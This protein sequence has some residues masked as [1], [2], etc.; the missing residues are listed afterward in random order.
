MN[1]SNRLTFSLV[2]SVLLVA[3]FALV[4]TVMAA[5]GGP[6]ATITIDDSPIIQ[7]GPD[8]DLEMTDDNV[9]VETVDGANVL[10]TDE[11]R[12]NLVTSGTGYFRVKVVF[13]EA[14]FNDD[15]ETD[16]D[17]TVAVNDLV[18]TDAAWTI[19]AGA[20]VGGAQLTGID[21]T[22]VERV[23]TN[24]DPDVTELSKTD[25][26]VTL[27][28]S[29]SDVPLVL[30]LTLNA[31]QVYGVGTA[32]QIVNGVP[33]Q[34]VSGTGNQ[35]AS[36]TFTVIS[37][38]L[39]KPTVAV[40]E[41]KIGLDESLTVT[42]TFD[43]A[44]MGDD[45]PSRTNIKVT[46]GSI[47]P[48]NP[49]TDGDDGLYSNAD[50]A[51]DPNT[52]WTIV[53][54]PQG[55]IGTFYKMKVE[56]IAGAP[57]V[58]SEEITVDSTPLEQRIDI[59]TTSTSDSRKGG[60]EFTVAIR[61]NVAPSS[62]LTADGVT[63]TGGAKGTFN[64]SG[65]D[66]TLVV[67][68]TD[69]AAGATGT[70]TVSVG[71]YSQSFDIPGVDV[72]TDDDDDDPTD[73]R[74]TSDAIAIPKNSFVVVVRDAAAT[75][76]P[77]GQVFRAGVTKVEWA[78][79]PN[80]QELFDRSAPGGGG[81]IVVEDASTPANIAVGRVGI[82][83][84]MWGIDEG[85]LGLAS[86]T[87]SQWIELHN[88]SDKNVM[89]KL[90]SL[91]GRDITDDSKITG[92][93]TAP[94]VDVVTNFFNN[95]IGNPAW[96][97]LGSNGNT[98]S[99]ASFVSM[100]R[101]LPHRKAAYADADGA[102]FSNRDGRA[103]GHWTSSSSV[104]VR[105][106]VAVGDVQVVY[107]YKGTP[108]QVNSFKPQTQPNLKDARTNVPSNG[109]VINE[110]ANRSD[111]D[112]AYEWI[113][114]YNA[115][116]GEIN[117]RNYRISK[118]ITNIND[119][120]LLDF[121]T[122]DN[123]KIGAG[124]VLLIVASD[125]AQDQEH[126][127]AVGYNVD[128]KAEEQAPGLADNPVRYKVLEFKN[129]GLP[130]NGKFVLIVRRPDNHENKN[131]AGKGPA[132]LGTADLDKIVD[133]AGWHD[134]LG[135]SNYSNPVSSTGL[136][137]LR[138]FAG[139]FTNRNQFGENSVHY[140]QYRTTNDGRSGVGAHENKNQDDRAAF[141]NAGFTG[142]GYKRRITSGNAYAG[143][144][145]YEN[146]VLKS[147]GGA[148]TGPVYISEIMYA[149]NKAGALPQWIELYNP[150]KTVGV[151]LHNWRLTIV[152][153][154]LMDD[155]GGLWPRKGEASVLLNNMKIDPNSTVLITSRK[156]P[157]SEVHLPNAD[158]FTLFPS[159]RAAFSMESINDNVIN[160]YGF[161]ITLHAK[162]NEASN[163]WELV[164]EVSN[165]AVPT[166]DRRGNRERFDAVRWA[167]PN[168]VNADGER[169]SIARKTFGGVGDGK[170]ASSWILSDG[171]GRTTKIDFVYYGKNTDFST[172]GQTVGQPLPVS[173]SYFRPTLENGEIVIRWTTESELDNAGFNILRSD[174]RNGEFKQVNAEMIHGHGTTGERHTYKWVDATAKPGFVYYY[175]IE[176][177]SFAGERQT[178]A[179]NRLKGLISAKNKAT[180]RW[181]ELKS[182]D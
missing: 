156:G 113:E 11:N 125:P 118:V 135:K 129:N 2:F 181:G 62:D 151:N 35:E 103:S 173:L 139:P 8:N 48:D 73:S 84:I 30:T 153:H 88:I 98:V 49:D 61:Y 148:V 91:T 10:L 93:L 12:E 76:I 164:D 40:S 17:A 100:A 28:V 83:E 58:L 149:D 46:N 162:G 145:G 152:S 59:T 1:L 159:H 96:D 155:E 29:Y 22:D 166:T 6:T 112:K 89:V 23:D 107:E 110:V 114:L 78:T 32:F 31:D 109:I 106:A 124:K 165:L 176:D 138:S 57:F 72:V 24:D 180:L 42:L 71:Q 178:L 154:D 134:S 50:A 70:L 18:T 105:K 13:S 92:N 143:T 85:K 119:Q 20:V 25:F 144:P 54:V 56:A 130:D 168:A 4:P 51:T 21:V 60:A 175:Q 137:P 39:L 163:R 67:N 27:S 133:I 167:W 115:S 123:A 45:V 52:I 104:Y 75:P 120:S 14:V 146:R 7:P 108:G 68:P 15:T 111:S 36:G 3:G 5:E 177:V 150:S 121:P 87:E 122:N 131:E 44:P 74:I 66:Y 26:M 80:L 161:K 94:T 19:V 34:A 33:Q 90:H 43:P 64:G 79:M 179:T 37:K 53:V 136:W 41:S 82:S 157:R 63:V 101:I 169:S 116:G 158:I 47:L 99:G 127:L 102:R 65:A 81:A 126:P 141:R 95:R 55:G 128:K 147:S 182:Q 117:L 9:T 69:P 38:E 142:V 160:T 77:E 140:R 172:P 97:V 171:D 132:E 174:S 86:Q 16:V 170:L